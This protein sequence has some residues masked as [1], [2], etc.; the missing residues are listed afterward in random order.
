MR[1]F[2]VR[3]EAWCVRHLVL[4]SVS[5][6][7]VCDLRYHVHVLVCEGIPGSDGLVVVV[8]WCFLLYEPPGV[9]CR[10]S[11]D[12]L[13]DCRISKTTRPPVIDLAKPCEPLLL[14]LA[15]AGLRRGAW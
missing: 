5:A 11:P 12:H 13:L 14:P 6:I 10:I 1:E 9:I 15:R 2:I 8:M 7:G 4:P 3:V